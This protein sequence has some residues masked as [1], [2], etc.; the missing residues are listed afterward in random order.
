MQSDFH[1]NPFSGFRH[2]PSRKSPLLSV[3]SLRPE[4]CPF[5]IIIPKS[6]PFVMH[7][8]IHMLNTS[9]TPFISLDQYLNLNLYTIPNTQNMRFFC[10]SV[11]VPVC[12]VS[13]ALCPSSLKTLHLQLGLKPHLPRISRLRSSQPRN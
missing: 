1:S 7:L 2:T 3:I 13:L 11:Y 4:L 5:I 6:H 12:F 8:I 9:V 10:C